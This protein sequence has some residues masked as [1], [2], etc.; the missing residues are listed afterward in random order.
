MAGNVTKW[1]LTIMGLALALG[2]GAAMWRGW[3]VVQLER[4]WSLVIAGAALLSGG[5][6]VL[7]LA[8][9]VARL[10]RLLAAQSLSPVAKAPS[11]APEA[12]RAVAPAPAQAPQE[13][14]APAPPPPPPPAASPAPARPELAPRLRFRGAAPAPEPEP[15]PAAAAE[16]PRQVDSYR[17]GDLTYV[18]YSDG[19]VEV[20]S[21][22]GVH[23]YA[24]LAE[25]REQA[26]QQN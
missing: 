9:V 24:S 15:E 19:S 7:A 14:P 22:A 2:G 5:V 26:M 21:A 17:S 8:T 20:R 16:E 1:A 6:V 11:A 23:R 10:D 25:L 18:M 3:D 12:P 13:E 4:G